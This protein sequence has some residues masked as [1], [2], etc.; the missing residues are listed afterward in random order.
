MCIP[1]LWLYVHPASVYTGLDVCTSYA[2]GCLYILY[3][4]LC[5][6]AVVW[7]NVYSLCSWLSFILCLWLCVLMCLWLCVHPGH[8]T[9][10]TP[11]AYGYVRT[12]VPVAMCTSCACDCPYTLCLRLCVLICL[13]LCVRP[14]HVTVHTPCACGYV[15]IVI[16]RLLY[17]LC[18]WLCVHPVP[19]IVCTSLP[20]VP[21][22]VRLW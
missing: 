22:Q 14:V 19:V 3:L 5:V 12:H 1:C 11:C 18:L 8:V 4:L 6:H 21:V 16:L 17:I 13:W 2:S 15:Y 9:V 10:H 7:C 20:V